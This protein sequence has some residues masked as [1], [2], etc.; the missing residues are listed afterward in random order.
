MKTE[1]RIAPQ[2]GIGEGI[3]TLHD[4]SLILKIDKAKLAAWLK[5]HFDGKFSKSAG[6]KYS[7]GD[8]R[9]T[10]FNF[11]TLMEL[12]VF[13]E[14][15]S[16]G[17][18]TQKINQSHE[19]LSRLLKTSYPFASSEIY[20]NNEQLLFKNDE[21]GLVHLDGTR[22]IA[23]KKVMDLYFK[24]IDYSSNIAQRYWPLGKDKHILVDPKLQF[25]QPTIV[26]TNITSENIYSY[27]K[28]GERVSKIA[29]VFNLTENAV[30]D[31]IDFMKD[32]A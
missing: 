23:F 28:A 17:L 26:G 9:E 25:G 32:A 20:T 27:Y 14:L 1:S 4:A 7:W 10:A 30:Q 16:L 12:F 13:N 15:K 19:E 29:K 6:H 31:T 5:G 18:S 22:Q 2:P 8:K 21:L 3:Y 11:L 24:K